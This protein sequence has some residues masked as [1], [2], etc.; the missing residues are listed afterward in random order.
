MLPTELLMFK[1]KAGLVEPR[2]LKPTP[3]NLTLVTSLVGVFESHLNDKRFQLEED[4]RA[5]E[6]G[7][8]DYRVV[9]GLAH[10]ISNDHAEF[11]T[12]G[13]LQPSLVRETVFELAQGAPASRTRTRHVLDQASKRLGVDSARR[14][15][16]CC[17]PP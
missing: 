12:G 4:V 2:R 17:T 13:D 11:E 1:V 16:T 7:R 15:W 14:R 10:L 6:V 9:R 8:S 3:S 5:L